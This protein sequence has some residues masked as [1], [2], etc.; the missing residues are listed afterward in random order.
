M[1]KKHYEITHLSNEKL[2]SSYEEIMAAAMAQVEDSVC[3]YR[4]L[5]PRG[6]RCIAKIKG[7]DRTVAHLDLQSNQGGGSFAEVKMQTLEDWGVAATGCHDLQFIQR[8]IQ[9]SPYEKMER[10]QEILKMSSL[11]EM[12]K[13]HHEWLREKLGYT[14]YYG[15]INVPYD[16]LSAKVNSADQPETGFI[17]IAF[18]G[19]SQE[20]DT[21]FAVRVLWSI[22]EAMVRTFTRSQFWFNL[23]ELEEIPNVKFWLDNFGIEEAVRR[24]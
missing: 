1:Q 13:I 8:L 2:I 6:W 11:E 14:N 15:G 22:Q 9:G 18:S 20:Q 7:A 10:G 23:R 24:F 3:R 21:M 5:L 19:A 17:Q 4:Y 12:R 16:E